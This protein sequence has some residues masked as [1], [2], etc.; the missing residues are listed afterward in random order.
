MVV[1]YTRQTKSQNPCKAICPAFFEANVNSMNIYRLNSLNKKLFSLSF[2]VFMRVL[3]NPRV[4]SGS[5]S[6]S[7]KRK[8]VLSETD[9]L[10]LW[11]D[12]K[13]SSKLSDDASVS[14]LQKDKNLS[15]ASEDLIRMFKLQLG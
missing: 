13:K 11:S 6:I 10:L 2:K 7:I 4:D 5:S 3:E 15:R 9:T 8:I 1:T 14:Q 12:I